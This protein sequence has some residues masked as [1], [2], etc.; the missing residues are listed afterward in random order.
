MYANSVHTFSCYCERQIDSCF[1]TVF[2]LIDYKM[3][4]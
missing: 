3:M 1:S 4:P 2:T